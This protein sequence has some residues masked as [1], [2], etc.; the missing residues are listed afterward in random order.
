[1]YVFQTRLLKWKFI[2]LLSKIRVFFWIKVKIRK[3]TQQ[4][5]C[6][7]A[8]TR[9]PI[10]CLFITWHYEKENYENKSCHVFIMNLI[11]DQALLVLWWK[12]LV[13]EC[14]IKCVSLKSRCCDCWVSR[15]LWS[16]ALLCHMPCNKN[17]K[18]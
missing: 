6:T 13:P 2:C 11:C 12:H 7:E 4:P 3:E 16:S 15:L 10:T 14:L 5:A 18:G 9:S 17:V 1:M 8:S